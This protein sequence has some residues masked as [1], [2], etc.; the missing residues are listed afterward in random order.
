MRA[1][2]YRGINSLVLNTFATVNPASNVF[3]YSQPNDRDSWIYL[4]GADTGSNWGMYHRQ[5]DSGVSGLPANSIGFIGGGSSSL[6][7]FIGLAD[8]SAFFK[9]NVGIGTMTPAYKLDVA[10]TGQFTQPVIVGTPTATNHAATKSYVDSAAGGGVGAGTSGQTLRHNGTNW[11]ANST[12]FNNGTNVGIGTASPQA[13]LDVNGSIYANSL[14]NRN[15]AG[16]GQYD[17]EWRVLNVSSNPGERTVATFDAGT[18]DSYDGVE[19]VGEVIDNQSN[20]GDGT[21]IVSNFR[22]RLRFS[23]GTSYVL[24]QDRVTPN[25]TLSIREVSASVAKLTAICSSPH[26][27]VRV[28]FKLIEGDSSSI[29]TTLGNP[30]TID[31]TGTTVVAAPSYMLDFSGYVGI[32]STIPA[33]NLD[34]NGTGRFTQPLI[35][36]TPTTSNHAATKSYVDSAAASAAGASWTVSG[37]NIYN[38][39]SGNVGIGTTAPAS[40]LHIVGT[41]TEPD[42][43]KSMDGETMFGG[44]SRVIIGYNT[45]DDYGLIASVNHGLA[46]KNLVFNPNGGN[47]GIGNSNPS[48]IL[49]VSGKLKL[50]NGGTIYNTDSSRYLDMTGTLGDSLK[51]SGNLYSTAGQLKIDGTG[52]SY[53]MGNLGIGINNPSKKL[54]VAGGHVGSEI[55]LYSVGDGGTNNAF[56]NLWAS[57]PTKTYTGVGISNNIRNYNGTS[58]FVRESTAR[59]GSY[60]RLLDSS[61]LFNV[62]DSSGTD[63]NSIAINRV[64]NVGIGTTSPTEAKLVINAGTGMALKAYGNGIFTGTLQTQTGSDFAEEFVTSDN[65]EPGTVVVMD[66][67][68]HKSVKPCAKSYDKTV[69][70]IVSNDP[71]IIAGRVNSEHKAIIAM[72]GVVKV[73]VSNINGNISKG[74][75]LTTSGIYGYAMKANDTKPG[76]VIGKALE[77]LNKATGEINVLVNL[78]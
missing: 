78:Q 60:I 49:D 70:G 32:G 56:L 44:S 40:K 5:I 69:V 37:N 58:A 14:F 77:N 72:M 45:S 67:N 13:K 41:T 42:M 74:D 26:K 64:G 16:I 62:V 65:L 50:T 12:L 3:L 20:W 55:Q 6:Q 38:S 18:V 52:A 31:T 23:G 21:P 46:W 68:G 19:I 76:T 73:K 25:I 66:D 51:V 24:Y 75:L 2:R 43:S 30:D 34:V 33:Y 11:V 36:G 53:L 10:G 71:S 15:G 47:I 28:K 7:A 27:D 54:V 35:V 17:Y 59:G 9:G 63:I 22:A 39:N 61:M 48:A 1:E 4:D 29:T 8:G 57:E